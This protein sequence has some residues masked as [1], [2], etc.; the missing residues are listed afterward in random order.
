MSIQLLYAGCE[1]TLAAGTSPSLQSIYPVTCFFKYTDSQKKKKKKV[2]NSSSRN[3]KIH[4]SL[5]SCPI[6]G[7]PI[8]KLSSLHTHSYQ[9]RIQL[10]STFPPCRY[11]RHRWTP[12]RDSL[13]KTRPSDVRSSTNSRK[14]EVWAPGST[15]WRKVLQA[16][17]GAWCPRSQ[18]CARR[19]PQYTRRRS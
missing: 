13:R 1:N 7:D 2:S 10:T 17:C 4:V 9:H 6:N 14:R 8:R 12:E 5:F 3:H 19:W 18:L 11:G 15:G 16:P